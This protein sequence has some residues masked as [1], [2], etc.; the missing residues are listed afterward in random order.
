L[1]A[2]YLLAQQVVE[3]KYE[4]LNEYTRGVDPG[5]NVRAQK[6]L[7][8]VF[9]PVDAAWRGFPAIPHS[10]MA[11]RKKYENLDAAKQYEDLLRDVGEIPEPAGCRCG[12]VL[13][14][15]IYAHECPLFGRKCTPETPVGPCMVSTE[16]ACNIE[17]RYHHD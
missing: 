14:G 17:Y 9:E 8:E 13:R 2:T 6:V 3:G 11:I 15:L 5:G 12:D 1:L 10:R 4:V 7:A 16:G